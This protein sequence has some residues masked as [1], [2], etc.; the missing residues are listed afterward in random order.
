MAAFLGQRLR[1]AGVTLPVV[2][3]VND[4]VTDSERL[5]VRCDN[6]EEIIAG[7]HTVRLDCQVVMPASAIARSA[8]ETERQLAAV[9]TVCHVALRE[10]YDGRGWKHQPLAHPQ[11]GTDA[12][13]EA[14]PFIVLDIFSDAAALE[15]ESDGYKAVLGF[16]AYVQF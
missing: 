4:P 8:A 16:K 7:N 1:A 10:G 14:E 15:A 3:Q 11:P 12:E 9:G 13:Y 6:A 5:E 2:G